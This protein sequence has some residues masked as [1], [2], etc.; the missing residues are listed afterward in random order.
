MGTAGAEREGREGEK[1]EKG[2]AKA[3]E[4]GAGGEEQPLFLPSPSFVA[5]AEGEE[6]FGAPLALS[7]SPLCN[8]CT[9][10]FLGQAWA[11]AT[12]GLRRAARRLMEV[13]ADCPRE[14][15]SVYDIYCRPHTTDD[16]IERLFNTISI[17]L[18]LR[19]FNPTPHFRRRIFHD[20]PESGTHATANHNLAHYWRQPGGGSF[21]PRGGLAGSVACVMHET[22][23]EHEVLFVQHRGIVL[24][25]P[26][27]NHPPIL[28]PA[29]PLRF[30]SLQQPTLP[31]NLFYPS[32]SL[33]IT[34][35]PPPSKF[36]I[37]SLL[38]LTDCYYATPTSGF[39]APCLP[40]LFGAVRGKGRSQKA[41]A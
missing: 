6:G 31:L 36:S 2:R 21:L 29:P 17:P 35:P 39:Q 4:L 16:E 38:S 20:P 13:G 9:S 22:Q 24:N 37:Y 14:P 25:S 27:K 41:P 34:S 1:E 8:W 33:P 3:E 26:K 32:Q 40:H 18:F 12:G 11:E 23:V 15:G 10:T 7:L 5:S 28:R 19:D 30:A